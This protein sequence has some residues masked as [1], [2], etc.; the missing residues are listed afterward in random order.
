MSTIYIHSKTAVHL[1]FVIRKYW[2]IDITFFQN[3][4]AVLL[5]Y[6]V[7]FLA[8]KV[9]GAAEYFCTVLPDTSLGDVI[10]RLN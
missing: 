9:V 2:G 10:N 3:I 5:V 7:A 8:V 6:E 4:W 1:I